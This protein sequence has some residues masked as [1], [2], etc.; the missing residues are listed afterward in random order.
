MTL[1]DSIFNLS[2]PGTRTDIAGYSHAVY[3]QYTPGSHHIYSQVLQIFRD[4]GLEY[5]LFA[6]SIIGYVRNGKM[7]YWM[8]DLDVIVFEEQIPLFETEV[9]PH[10]LA[11][12]FNCYEPV[13]FEKGG[14]HILA[15]Q[16]GEQR[17]LTIPLSDSVNVSVPWAQID[18]FYAGV[19]D[20]GLLR[21]PADWGLYHESDIPVDWVRPGKQVEIEGWKT[22]IF[23]NYREDIAKEYG[24]VNNHIVVASH[25]RMYLNMPKTSWAD[26]DRDFQALIERTSSDLPPTVD[27]AALKRF[28][29]VA[30][31]SVTTQPAQ[32]YAAIAGDVLAGQAA[33]LHLVDEDQIYWAMDLKRLFPTLV[34]SAEVHSIRGAQR[35]AHLRAFID[36]LVCATPELTGAY[37]GY[38]A[39]LS[40][41]HP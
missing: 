3:A 19:N 35:A 21:S 15:L 9:R 39:A 28:A 14:Y 11:C 18:V 26:F 36:R 4:F 6:G 5:Y 33:T 25:G 37:D 10:L 31:N 17:S 8:D 34:I 32:S 23:S 27:A 20:E 41:S 12:G 13:G 22:R 40:R 24:D 7:P 29:P 16:Q 38:V 30:Q 1:A 2:Q